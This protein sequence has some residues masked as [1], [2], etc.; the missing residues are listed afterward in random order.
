MPDPALERIPRLPW[1]PY[2][3]LLAHLSAT[4]STCDRG[5]ELLLDVGRRGVGAVVVRANRVIA[6]GYNGSPPGE[7]HCDEA[8]HILVDDHCV[9]CLHAEENALLQ[10]ALDGVSPAGATVFTTASPC[11]DCAKRILR[12]GIVRVVFGAAYESRYGLS[13]VADELLARGPVFVEY[14]DVS[15]VIA[16]T[17]EARAAAFVRRALEPTKGGVP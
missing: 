5:P 15:S 1:D 14:L 7:A 6:T 12:A 17:N 10:C 3:M 2:W 13:R 16:R 4:R 9:R 8:G 11:Y